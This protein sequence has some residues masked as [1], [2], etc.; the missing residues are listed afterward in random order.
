M[1]SADAPAAPRCGDLIC[2]R[3]LVGVV[4]YQQKLFLRRFRRQGVGGGGVFY[5]SEYI[6]ALSQFLFLQGQIK[7]RKARFCN[8]GLT[9]LREE[10]E[11]VD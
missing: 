2:A 4:Y 11:E 8:Q 7:D 6:A 5:P 10:E 3:L 1:A 9:S